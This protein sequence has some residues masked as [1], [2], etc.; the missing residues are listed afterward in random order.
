MHVS[1][2]I[3][4]KK[5][6]IIKDK[7]LGNEVRGEIYLS[8]FIA[9]RMRMFNEKIKKEN[10]EKRKQMCR[11]KIS[12]EKK[13]NFVKFYYVLIFLVLEKSTKEKPLEIITHWLV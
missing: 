1:R 2:K 9:L 11:E 5:N 7:S 12:K 6:V 4:E 10:K 8:A 3:E 13:S